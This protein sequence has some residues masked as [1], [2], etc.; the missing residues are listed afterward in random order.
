MYPGSSYPAFD[1]TT[2]HANFRH[3]VADIAWFGLSFAATSRFLSVYAIRLGATP[4]QLGL[5]TGLPPLMWLVSSMLSGWWSGRYPNMIPAL[6]LPTIGMRL[7]FALPLFAPLFPANLQVLWLILVATLTALPQGIANVIFMNILRKAV[8]HPDRMTVLLA[9]RQLFFNIMLAAGSLGF[10]FWLEIGPF[11]ANYM[12]MFALA[13]VATVLSYRA[14]MAVRVPD[15]A[16]HDYA[17]PKARPWASRPF[18]QVALSAFVIHL[19]FTSVNAIIPLRLVNELGLGEGF[20]AIYGLVEIGAAALVSLVAA[21]AARRL[22]SQGL[23]VAGMVGSAVAMLLIGLSENH[24]IILVG[25]ALSGASWT[26]AAGIGLFRFFIERSP[27]D[28]GA[29]DYTAAYNQSIGVALFAGPMIGSML[30][31]GGMNLVVVL[32]VGAFLRFASA[33]VTEYPAF[34]DRRR[35]AR[36]VLAQGD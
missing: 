1:Q 13:T 17:V 20:M 24:G 15:E 5:L 36:R 4:M 21:S 2:E 32:L 29:V 35:A 23:I 3:L 19:A 9:R 18:R 10:G 8:P 12:V 28:Q 33:V 26:L 7:I 34:M 14:C 16:P 22:G 31:T 6:R 11:P 30:A 25:A 27:S